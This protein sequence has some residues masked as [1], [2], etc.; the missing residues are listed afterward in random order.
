MSKAPKVLYIDIET[1]LNVCVSFYIGSKVS[2]SAEQIIKE[3]AIICISYMW[4]TWSKPKTV[5]W[6][7]D[8]SDKELLIKLSKVISE[9]DI[10]V[11]HNGDKY[12]IPFINGRLLYHK[13]P[14]LGPIPSVDTLKYSRGSFYLNSHRL[15]YLGKYCKLGGKS[16][17]GGL[18][19][20]IDITVHNNRKEMKLMGMYCE[21]DVILLRD[22]YK[23]VSPYANSRH[24]I[25]IMAGGVREDCPQCG[26]DSPI[27][28]GTYTSSIGIYQ[29]YR[30]KGCGHVW[31]DGRKI[32]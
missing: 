20:W 9:A 7:K 23:R 1:S 24:H 17:T 11:H 2:L 16:D 28:W 22:F 32:K 18:K 12:D 3:R 21:R 19:R 8:Q 26:Q 14:P 25:G 15:D 27:K 5:Y 30:C 31:K 13:L 29:K 4:D 6:D 10:L